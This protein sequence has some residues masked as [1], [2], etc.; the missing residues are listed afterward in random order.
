MVTRPL[1]ERSRTSSVG[2]IARGPRRWSIA[3]EQQLGAAVA[4][5]A[6][7]SC[8]RD[9]V[10]RSWMCAGPAGTSST[11]RTIPFQFHQASGSIGVLAAVHDHHELVGP[12]GAQAAGL[13]RERRVGVDVAADAAP[14]Q[15]H[16]RVAAHALEAN[17]PAEAAR[18]GRAREAARGSGAPGRDRATAGRACRTRSARCVGFQ[19]P[20]ACAAR[21]A[22]VAG[23]PAPRPPGPSPRAE[24]PGAARGR[25]P[26]R[27]SPSRSRACARAVATACAE[28]R[29]RRGEGDQ[30]CRMGVRGAASRP[31]P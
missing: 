8:T 12:A 10:P 31:S 11:G 17:Q 29:S 22:G 26:R 25:P 13:E 4:R 2:A 14:V 6:R 21:P 1:G 15:D 19:S 23:A 3:V 16:G 20:G 18:R 24:P 28:R 30:A 5:R 9:I 27:A 7:G